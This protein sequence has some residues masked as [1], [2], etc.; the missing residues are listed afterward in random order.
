MK[1][2]LFVGLLGAVILVAGCVKTVNDRRTAGVPWVKD[3]VTGH[4][5]RPLDQVYDAAKDVVKA[6][7]TILNET[8]LHS[9]TN[10]VKTIEGKVN[11][12]NVWVR[13][14]PVDPKVTGVA[15][16]TRTSGGVSDIELAHEIEKQI[17]LKLAHQ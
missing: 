12:R 4:Y 1:I 16:Q 9:D 3:K 14:E 7:G 5:E 8:I 10:E 13:V 6:N 11:Q 2:K 15:V 17:A